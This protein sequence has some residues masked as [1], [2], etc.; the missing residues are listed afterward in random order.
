MP[1]P[2]R[3][4]ARRAPPPAEVPSEAEADDASDWSADERHGEDGKR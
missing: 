1:K 4:K 2:R 3:T